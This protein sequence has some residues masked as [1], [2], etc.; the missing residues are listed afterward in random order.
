[1]LIPISEGGWQA[2]GPSAVPHKEG[3][4]PP[5]AFDAAGLARGRGAFIAA[6][7]RAERLGLDGLELHCAHGYLLH[8]F[9]SPISNRR[10]DRYGGS[11]EKRMRLPLEVFDAVRAAFP[12]DKPLGGK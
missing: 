5:R 2:E 12:D 6:A 3:E 8:Q 1:Q 7:K 9:L 11:L 10:T 4:A